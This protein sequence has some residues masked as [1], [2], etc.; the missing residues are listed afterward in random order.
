MIYYEYLICPLSPQTHLHI[1]D[2]YPMYLRRR[3]ES[4]LTISSFM[5]FSHADTFMLQIQSAPWTIG[6]GS[7]CVKAAMISVHVDLI[8]MH[9]PLDAM[10]VPADFYKWQPIVDVM[11][12][13]WLSSISLRCHRSDLLTVPQ[14]KNTAAVY[15]A[16][17]WELKNST[18]A[19]G[20]L[21]SAVEDDTFWTVW[22]E[23]CVF[24]HH[25]VASL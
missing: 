11:N 1:S 22:R 19:A 14:S 13:K 2:S 4:N 20:L 7:L 23:T 21:L 15:D 12:P 25:C 10:M 18:G 5:Y 6:I 3:P 24:S 17:S 16:A 9:Y 8:G